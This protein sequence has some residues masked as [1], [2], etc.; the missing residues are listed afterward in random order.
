[1]QI[2]F[3]SSTVRSTELAANW[4]LSL[5]LY[6]Y[7]CIYV[8]LVRISEWSSDCESSSQHRVLRQTGVQTGP[9]QTG[10]AGHSTCRYRILVFVNHILYYNISYS[11]HSIFYIFNM[12]HLGWLHKVQNFSPRSTIVKHFQK[13]NILYETFTTFDQAFDQIYS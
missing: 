5:R 4:S 3:L 10:L 12:D 2:I 11:Y 6:L 9:D 8:F 1:M 7:L 13:Q